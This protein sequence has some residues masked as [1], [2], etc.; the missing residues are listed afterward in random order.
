MKLIIQLIVFASDDFSR[1]SEAITHV[2]FF[3][4]TPSRIQL[5]CVTLAVDLKYGYRRRRL[6][7]IDKTGK[8]K[9]NWA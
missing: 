7:L 5:F 1:L 2:V 4:E 8:W 6:R 9:A 3:S